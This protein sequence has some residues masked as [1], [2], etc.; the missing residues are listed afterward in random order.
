MPMKKLLM[1]LLILFSCG[2]YSGN[3]QF[4]IRSSSSGL[5]DGYNEYEVSLNDLV[6]HTIKSN[7]WIIVL[8]ER[9]EK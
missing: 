2:C 5:S 4:P 1:I 3:I 6:N 9:Y 7:D 8:Y